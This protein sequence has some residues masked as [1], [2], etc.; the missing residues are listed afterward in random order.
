[1]FVRRPRKTSVRHL[2][3]KVHL[4][5][6]GSALVLTGIYFRNRWVMW[7]ALVLLAAAFMVRFLPRDSSV[8]DDPSGEE[9]ADGSD[10]PL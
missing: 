7:G 9:R 2:D 5:M 1:M 4:F 8:D 3:W 6:A 10:V